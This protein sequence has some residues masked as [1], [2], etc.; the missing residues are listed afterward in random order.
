[1]AVETITNAQFHEHARR[2][3]HTALTTELILSLGAVVL[4]ILEI[5]GVFPIYLAAIAV[6]GIG[7]VLLFQ[8]A[9]VGLQYSE[10][11]YDAGATSKVG[12]PY[13][14]R[15]IT[16]DLLA[17]MAGIVLGVLALLGIVP[18]TLLSVTVITYGGALLLTSGELVWLNSLDANENAM[19]RRLRRSMS[20]A[21]A[22]AQVLVGMAGV[23]LGILGLVGIASTTMVLVA[24]LATGA[25][26]LLRG[27]SV[28]GL[29][30]D[31]LQM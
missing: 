15:G 17:G 10:L 21:A 29:L 16:A 22:G 27:S 28:G 14:S 6:I 19:V 30:Q 11:L 25:S 18:M 13:V 1:M 24:L 7:A 9:N 8:S 3:E 4:S 23:V 12:V 26:I 2:W 20:V 31:F 5:L